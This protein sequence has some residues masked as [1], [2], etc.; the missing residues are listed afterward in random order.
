MFVRQR[1][2][3]LVTGRFPEENLNTAKVRAA[4]GGVFKRF[5]EEDLDAAI[6]RADRAKVLGGSAGQLDS[7]A[8][9]HG[10]VGQRGSGA[11][12]EDELAACAAIPPI[13]SAKKWQHHTVSKALATRGDVQTAGVP[14]VQKAG[15]Q[16]DGAPN[17]S[18]GKAAPKKKAATKPL[19]MTAKCIASRAYH[20]TRTKLVREGMPKEEAMVAAR[21]AH[22][23]AMREHG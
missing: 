22:A 23:E 12:L 7:G 4:H 8:L 3:W 5:S 13:G 18:A 17:V 20:Q 16:K 1:T 11:A 19:K 21:K 2:S 14:V 6:A 15:A 10:S 9:L